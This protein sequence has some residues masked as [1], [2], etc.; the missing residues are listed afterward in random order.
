MS[1]YI[2]PLYVF[3]LNFIYVQQK[4][5]IKVQIWWN[6]TWAV[7]SLKF[8]TLIFSFCSNHIKF[9]LKMYRRVISHTTE[10]WSKV[11]RK[12]N[13][14]FQIWHEEFDEFSPNHSKVWK[15]HF[16]GLFLSKVYE[17]WAKKI[18]RSYLSW[19]WTVMQNLNKPWPCGFKNGMRNWMNFH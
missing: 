18:Q 16:D 10:E 4:E 1:W 13:L 3:S 5:P 11:W 17:V 12:T 14:W 7:E 19:H 2:T 6:F 9:Q 15:F 8:C